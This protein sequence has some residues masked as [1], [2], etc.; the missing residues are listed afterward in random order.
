MEAVENESNRISR[1]LSDLTVKHNSLCASMAAYSDF[2]N[3]SIDEHERSLR[4]LV[5]K[6]RDSC[7]L[8]YL[9]NLMISR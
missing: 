6:V 2:N 1:S 5:K 7:L 8:S 9:L 4:D 3:D